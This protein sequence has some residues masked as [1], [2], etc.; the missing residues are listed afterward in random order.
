M[1]LVMRTCPTLPRPFYEKRPDILRKSS[2][3]RG[4][5]GGDHALLMILKSP[6]LTRHNG[7]RRDR[8]FFCW[9]ALRLNYLPATLNTSNRRSRL[10]FKKWRQMRRIS[11][12]ARQSMSVDLVLRLETVAVNQRMHKRVLISAPF[13]IPVAM[14]STP[15]PASQQTA[16]QPFNRALVHFKACVCA[17]NATF[18]PETTFSS[19]RFPTSL[20]FLDVLRLIARQFLSE[21]AEIPRPTTADT[22][23]V[24]RGPVA[25]RFPTCRTFHHIS[26]IQL[27]LSAHYFDRLGLKTVGSKT[28]RSSY[29][30]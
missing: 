9:K 19:E 14:I 27:F 3:A 21:A 12:P 24:R 13:P 17:P 7:G 23:F 20:G 15:L 18:E 10:C 29:Q 11:L 2:A 22:R 25:G 28:H 16:A 5:N 30:T 8:D 26:K 4:E 6:L 1:R